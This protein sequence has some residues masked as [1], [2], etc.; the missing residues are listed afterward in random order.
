M[1]HWIAI[2]FIGRNRTFLSVSGGRL[3]E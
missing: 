1:Q 3:Y 2:T